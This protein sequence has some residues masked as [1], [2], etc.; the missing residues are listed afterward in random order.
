MWISERVV[1]K[2]Q[3]LLA[4]IFRTKT[5]ILRNRG[6]VPTCDVFSESNVY[7]GLCNWP[8]GLP[9][10][11]HRPD[12]VLFWP[13]EID[14]NTLEPGFHRL[15]IQSL[16]PESTESSR[17]FIVLDA[18][19]YKDMVDGICAENVSSITTVR[20]LPASF[21]EQ[22][23]YSWRLVEQYLGID[24]NRDHIKVSLRKSRARFG[25]LFTQVVVTD[26]P[27]SPAKN[28][29]DA[30]KLDIM[31]I[32]FHVNRFVLNQLFCGGDVDVTTDNASTLSFHLKLRSDR[33]FSDQLPDE[34]V[35]ISRTFG[36]KLS[37]KWT[38]LR[39]N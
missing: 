24:D 39:E 7:R 5:A 35:T 28:R 10:K 4:G 21:E 17:E 14:T 18:A 23:L 27:P 15:T 30:E 2:G 19:S 34:L 33:A 6:S 37:L 22:W 16:E 26:F 25:R 38:A 1:R 29:S 32:N 8:N 12:E 36:A 3:T 31:W 20:A 11:R 13:F 9:D